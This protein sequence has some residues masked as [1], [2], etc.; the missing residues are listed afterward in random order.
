MAKDIP[1][2]PESYSDQEIWGWVLLLALLFIGIARESN[3]HLP[4]PK[5][6]QDVIW[7]RYRGLFG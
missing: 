6:T 3:L 2:P 7:S 5:D 4:V 1:R